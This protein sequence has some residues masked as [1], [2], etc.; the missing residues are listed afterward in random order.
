MVWK[1]LTEESNSRSMV[2]PVGEGFVFQA[3]AS[4]IIIVTPHVHLVALQHHRVT[5]LMYAMIQHLDYIWLWDGDDL[6]TPSF[7]VLFYKHPI[8]EIFLSLLQ[9]TWFQG[10]WTYLPTDHSQTLWQTDLF[11]RDQGTFRNNQG[12]QQPIEVERCCRIHRVQDTWG[13][14]WLGSIE[15]GTVAM[16]C[17][18]EQEPFCCGL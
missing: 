11:A 17:P 12:W 8:I 3:R 4:V 16:Y 2:A 7:L 9:T 18:L 10:L 15:R 14:N 5:H 13:K 1:H 6:K